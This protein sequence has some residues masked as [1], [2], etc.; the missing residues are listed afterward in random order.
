MSVAQ[1]Q[2]KR[3]RQRI[4][5]WRNFVESGA[6]DWFGSPESIMVLV[7]HK[8]LLRDIDPLNKHSEP[9]LFVTNDIA[10]LREKDSLESLREDSITTTTT[11]RSRNNSSA[12]S[13]TCSSLPKLFLPSISPSPPERSFQPHPKPIVTPRTSS[14]TS[15]SLLSPI[16]ATTEPMEPTETK[17]PSPYQS[18]SATTRM[19]TTLKR[20][21]SRRG[22]RE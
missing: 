22:Q 14:L 19:I 4:A 2:N 10:S 21:I 3:L 18:R 11:T 17:H 8:E 13:D 9:D 6:D 20:T 15:L 12:T 16:P 1:L 5:K 7:D